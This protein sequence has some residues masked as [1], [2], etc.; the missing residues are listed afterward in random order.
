MWKSNRLP[1]SLEVV[2]ESLSPTLEMVRERRAVIFHAAASHGRPPHVQ[3]T[4]LQQKPTDLTM[5]ITGLCLGT[6]AAPLGVTKK[7]PQAPPK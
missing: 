1:P 3:S 7:E 2:P 6:H 5:R 4:P